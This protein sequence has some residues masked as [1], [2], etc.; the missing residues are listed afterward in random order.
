LGR[1]F[2]PFGHEIAPAIGPGVIVGQP[3]RMDASVIYLTLRDSGVRIVLW[4]LMM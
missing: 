3:R 2:P 4:V 1:T